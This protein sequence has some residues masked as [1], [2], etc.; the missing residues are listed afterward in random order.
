MQTVPGDDFISSSGGGNFTSGHGDG[1]ISQMAQPIT[2]GLTWLPT[3][4]GD[5]RDADPK[6][7]HEPYFEVHSA[8]GVD[9]VKVFHEGT[10]E[11]S[12]VVHPPE[13]Q[14]VDLWGEGNAFDGGLPTDIS[15]TMFCLYSEDRSGTGDNPCTRLGFGVPLRRFALPTNGGYFQ[16]D[17]TDGWLDYN[18]TDGAGST[19]TEIGIRTGTIA[20]IPQGLP[21]SPIIGQIVMD[22]DDGN[23]VKVY[24]GSSW[25]DMSN[26]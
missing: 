25:V 20:L 3:L 10:G 15:K 8:N 11:G 9:T 18:A 22:I 24:N 6:Y 17:V 7:T 12:I 4:D 2:G 1:P 13:L 21:S 19:D 5:H 16:L 23:K 14:D 26:A